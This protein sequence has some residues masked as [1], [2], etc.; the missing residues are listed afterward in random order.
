M[1]MEKL[2]GPAQVITFL[3]IELDSATM[4]IR[5]PRAKLLWLQ[6]ELGKWSERKACRKKDLLSLIGQLAHA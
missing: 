6:A 4:Q 1:A 5:H 3:G 2:E